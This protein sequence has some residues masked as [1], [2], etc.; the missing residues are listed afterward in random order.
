MKCTGCSQKYDLQCANL[1][2][3]RYKGLNDETKRKWKCSECICKLPK[4]DNSDTPARASSSINT[5][6]NDKRGTEGKSLSSGSSVES[7]KMSR[8]PSP[9]P[10]YITEEKMREMLKADKQDLQLV[11]ESCV[12]GLSDQINE[13]KVQGK[14]YQESLSFVSKQYDE[15]RSELADLKK[16]FGS[17]SSELKSIREDNKTLRDT[18]TS[19]AARIK[20]LKEEST[21]QAQWS[22]MQNIE[23]TGI[24]EIKDE[25]TPDIVLKIAHH[26]GVSIEASDVEFAHR[27]Q[28][29][30]AASTQ[31]TPRSIIV[32][33]KQRA[34]KDR[35]V[36]AG[37]KY[38]NICARELGLGG[39]PHRVFINEH[40]IRE[41][42]MLLST[43]TE[44][45]FKYVWTKNC[46]IYVRRN[47]E[48]PPIAITCSADLSK[49]F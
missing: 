21:K 36:A 48:S 8:K 33:I 22:R 37:R 43:A 11:I 42:K 47:E 34:L 14:G 1:S 49:M 2:P 24:P 9:S 5:Q 30:H 7:T 31:R 27:V 6:P 23:I 4:T 17:T 38:R 25:I 40:L 13:L 16:M 19:Q 46:R 35:L 39:E 44:K 45:N 29:R 26:I 10:S 12:N 18:I 41:N 28:P 3:K 20:V 15:L 32:R